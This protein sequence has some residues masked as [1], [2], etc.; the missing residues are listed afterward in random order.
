M[1]YRNLTEFEFITKQRQ[2]KGKQ[3][4]QRLKQKWSTIMNWEYPQIKESIGAQ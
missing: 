1:K 4:E 3:K 2:G